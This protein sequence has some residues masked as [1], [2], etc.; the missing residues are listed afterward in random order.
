MLSALLTRL[1]AVGPILFGIGFFA[2]V[3]AALVEASGL[4]LPF[5]ADPLYV[6]LGIGALWGAIAAKRGSWV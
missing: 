6:G 3:F 4:T 5:G 1:F 2:P